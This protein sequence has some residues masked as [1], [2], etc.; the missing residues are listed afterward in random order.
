MPFI[1][2]SKQADVVG[3]DRYRDEV[4]G[5]PLAYRESISHTVA[6]NAAGTSNN[7]TV[8]V[9]AP[10]LVT[11]NGITTSTD[12][13]LATAKFTSLQKIT[14]DATRAKCYDDLIR[15][16]IATRAA[17][18]DGQLPQKANLP[19]KWQTFDVAA[20]SAAMA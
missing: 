2:L 13:F 12:S 14:D 20:V 18:L 8:K 17:N 6:A 10:S 11:V 15:F 7:V 3:S 9:T 5:T 16:L 4:A 1:T 19:S